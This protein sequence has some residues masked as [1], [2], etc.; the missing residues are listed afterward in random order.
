MSLHHRLI[1]ILYMYLSN[2]LNFCNNPLR[3]CIQFKHI[4]DIILWNPSQVHL[5]LGPLVF[6][7]CLFFNDP[8]AHCKWTDL[9]C[10][11]LSMV[12]ST[13]YHPNRKSQEQFFLSPGFLWY[14]LHHFVTID[15]Y[16][17]FPYFFT[18]ISPDWL[19]AIIVDSSPTRHLLIIPSFLSIVSF[20]PFCSVYV[21]AIP[22]LKY[23]LG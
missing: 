14:L 8:C 6:S 17:P 1:E 11:H 23:P 21:H 19:S 15:T 10:F 22:S 2:I 20:L 18:L 16:S 13:S 12:S 3:P 4:V 9:Y 5:L 7:V